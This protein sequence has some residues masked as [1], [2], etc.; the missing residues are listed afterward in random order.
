VRES[1]A[2]TWAASTGARE[3]HA[4]MH[5]GQCRR[6][7]AHM[8]GAHHGAALRVTHRRR[9]QRPGTAKGKSAIQAREAKALC[10]SRPPP[11]SGAT[12]MCYT[13]KA[14]NAWHCRGTQKTGNTYK[15]T[16]SMVQPGQG[17]PVA[18]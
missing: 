15:G 9:K 6:R 3:L 5:C 16:D 10:L 12:G 11:A 2:V 18:T 8:Y 4:H 1:A 7:L 13:V 17:E 14:P